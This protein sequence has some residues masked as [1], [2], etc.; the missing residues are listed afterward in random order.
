MTLRFWGCLC[1]LA[2]PQAGNSV[3]VLSRLVLWFLE[4]ADASFIFCMPKVSVLGEVSE[5][6]KEHAWKV[7]IS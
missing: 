1:T 7:C 3:S 2:R 5:W 6:P 4:Q